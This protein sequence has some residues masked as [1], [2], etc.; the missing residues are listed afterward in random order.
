LAHCDA[1]REGGNHSIYLPAYSPDL[2]PI[3]QAFSKLKAY[4]RK[5]GERNFTDLFEALGDICHIFTPEECW[6]YFQAAG[7][8][9]G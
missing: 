4:L 8:V 3:E 9:S 1:V 2:N 7:Y 6:N 5:I